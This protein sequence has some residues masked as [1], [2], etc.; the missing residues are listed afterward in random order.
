METSSLGSMTDGFCILATN[1]GM[2]LQ[3]Q[4]LHFTLEAMELTN[5]SS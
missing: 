1:S 3:L 5:V 4:V 2:K